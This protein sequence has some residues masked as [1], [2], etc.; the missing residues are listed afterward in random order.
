MR[1]VGR[2]VR[3]AALYV[4]TILLCLVAIHHVHQVSTRGLPRWKGG[5]FGMFSA[6]DSQDTRFVRLYIT[7]DQGETFPARV[8][9]HYIWQFERARFLPDDSETDAL[10]NA[11]LRREW[12]WTHGPVRDA[13]V[14]TG[15]VPPTIRLVEDR[16]PPGTPRV[17]IHTL[18]LEVHTLSYEPHSHR[19]STQLLR[20]VESHGDR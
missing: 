5:G 10:A 3:F 14:A 18:R 20:A 11:L 16:D 6:V 15:Q 17:R 7:T 13:R 4:P 1:S 12:V 2:P 9:R 19:L 8:P